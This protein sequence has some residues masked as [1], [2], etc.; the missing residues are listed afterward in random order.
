VSE[1]ESVQRAERLRAE[2]ESL[3]AGG[4]PGDVLEG[5]DE[6]I[7]EADEQSLTGDGSPRPA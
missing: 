6:A 7:A 5:L 2:R 4:A 3:A 1:Q